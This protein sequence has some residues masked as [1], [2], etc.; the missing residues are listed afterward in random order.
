MFH[1]KHEAAPLAPIAHVCQTPPERR[2]SGGEASGA[3]PVPP[4][5]VPVPVVDV[6]DVVLPVAPPEPVVVEDPPVDPPVAPFVVLEVEVGFVSPPHAARR[7]A[8]AAG[9]QKNEEVRMAGTATPLPRAPQR[10]STNPAAPGPRDAF[11]RP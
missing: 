10:T 2:G 5:P 3:P 1:P 6:V 4:V 8:P 9:A 11:D 7:I